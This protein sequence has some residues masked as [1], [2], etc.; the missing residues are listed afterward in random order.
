M[1]W[2][3]LSDLSQ[4]DILIN[5]S[6]SHTLAIFKHST[7]CSISFSVKDR[8]ERNH[9]SE[10]DAVK[11]Y[12]LDLINHRDVSNALSTTFSVHHESPQLLLIKDGKCVFYASHYDIGVKDILGHI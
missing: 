10:L 8:L 7:R 5:E 11:F 2:H 1:E 3:P 6:K 9:T 12:Y 4:I